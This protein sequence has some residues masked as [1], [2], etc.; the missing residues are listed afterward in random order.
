[1]SSGKL[2][3]TTQLTVANLHFHLVQDLSHLLIQN[4]KILGD[5]EARGTGKFSS[6]GVLQ[7]GFFQFLTIRHIPPIGKSNAKCQSPKFK[8]MPRSKF[9]KG[10]SFWP[11]I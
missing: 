2:S 6:L 5:F 1:M 3:K 8:L 9:E 11:R 4:A 10:L 7:N